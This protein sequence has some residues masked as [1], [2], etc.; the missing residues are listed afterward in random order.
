MKLTK[1]L[2]TALTEAKKKADTHA[3]HI[4]LAIES[5]QNIC[6]HKFESDSLAG[7]YEKPS[8]KICGFE[9]KPVKNGIDLNYLVIDDVEPKNCISE[10]E[11]SFDDKFWKLKHGQSPRGLRHED[12]RPNQIKIKYQNIQLD[13]TGLGRYI[14]YLTVLYTAME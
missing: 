2:F 11:L 10:Y 3:M 6:E 13:K 12:H 4:D 1:E 7:Q 5:L 9:S 14:E 8:C